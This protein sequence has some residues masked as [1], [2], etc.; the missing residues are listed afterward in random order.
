MIKPNTTS[1]DP[2]A[3]IEL[4]ELIA[5]L[6]SDAA[7]FDGVIIR[8]VGMKHAN[9]NDFY[10]GAGAA[11]AGGRW[12]PV[13][14]EAIYA[15]LDVMTATAEAY[16]KLIYFNVPMTTIMPRVS[17]GAAVS[18]A[19]VL[20]LTNTRILKK[21]D[22]TTKEMVEEDWRSLQSSGEESWT[23]AIGR[24]A[25]LAKFEGL[26][27]PSARKEDGKNIVVFPQRLSKTSKIEILGA[28]QLPK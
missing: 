4:F 1:T 8:S 18:L 15:S 12:N 20:D 28:E 11:K 6:Y 2:P 10:S 21:I 16:Q 14:L 25:W 27:V 17:A 3:V 26:I 24:G 7:G 5:E 9:E 13:G 23:Q 19:K 22:F